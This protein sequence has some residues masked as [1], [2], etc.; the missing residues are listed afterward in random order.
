MEAIKYDPSTLTM[1][2]H[3]ESKTAAKQ[4]NS[5]KS[6]RSYIIKFFLTDPGTTEGGKRIGSLACSNLPLKSR[7][8]SF[9]GE[10]RWGERSVH[11]FDF[12][13]IIS[14]GEYKNHNPMNKSF[15]HKKF[16]GEIMNNSPEKKGHEKTGISFPNAIVLQ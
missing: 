16:I 15:A 10:V 3:P 1:I 13:G 5:L 6:L 7:T 12:L 11:N 2:N 4:S 9:G 14:I 8:L